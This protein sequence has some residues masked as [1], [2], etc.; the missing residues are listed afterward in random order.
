[1]GSPK[2]KRAASNCGKAAVMRYQEAEADQKATAKDGQGV[3]EEESMS[4]YYFK[5]TK[6]E[7]NEIIVVIGGYGRDEF[8][9]TSLSV[10]D[11]LL[12][13]LKLRDGRANL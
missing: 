11:D 7:D 4:P 2:T 10:P 9:E 12:Y 13:L 3:Q 6:V 1:M 8:E 5:S